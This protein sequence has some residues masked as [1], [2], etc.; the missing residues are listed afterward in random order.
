MYIIILSVQGVNV[1]IIR[2]WD[3]TQIID[4]TNTSVL[5]TRWW[6]QDNNM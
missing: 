4:I 3:F 1:P 5:F 2:Q 6:S